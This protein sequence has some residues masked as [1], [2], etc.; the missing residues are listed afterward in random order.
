MDVLSTIREIVGPKY[1]SDADFVRQSY[2]KGISGGLVE[3]RPDYVVRPKSAEEIAEI[4]KIA[5]TE[6]VPVIPRGGGAGLLDGVLPL[7]SGGIVVDMTRMNHVLNFNEN[8]MTV[9]VECGITWAQLNDFLFE[10]GYYTGSLGPGSGMSAAIGGGLSHHSVGGGGAAKYGAVTRHCVGLKVVL[11][12]GSII[13]TGSGAS[14][15]VKEPFSRWGF[16]P[17]LTSIF[18]GDQGIMGIKVEATLMVY[19]KPEFRAYNTFMIK[20]KAPSI[21]T[22]ILLDYRKSGNLGIYDA[23]WLPDLSVSAGLGLIVQDFIVFKLWKDVNPKGKDVFFYTCEAE[24]EEELEQNVKKL[25]ELTLK[26]KG[27]TKFGPEIEDGN[28]AKWHYEKNGHWQIYHGFWGAAGPGSIPQT[29]EHHLPIHQIPQMIEAFNKWETENSELLNAAGPAIHG[30]GSALLCDHTTVEMDSGLVVR[31]LPE[32]REVNEKLWKSNLEMIVKS[33]GMPYMAGMRFSRALIDVGAFSDPYYNFLKA[34]K[35]T[36]DPEGI[37][38][39]GK[40]YL[41]GSF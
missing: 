29:A 35:Q 30:L 7:R 32:Y 3:K 5:S 16:G 14:K 20:R 31:N 19:P 22:Q 23:Y 28:I 11:A 1:V 13:T 4:L 38:S 24:S 8:A 25:N 37:I 10:R 41:G 39:P 36:L 33:G 34:I 40:F 9:T 21:V 26:H 6:K 18:L 15:Y 17:D 12:D 2:G 27:V